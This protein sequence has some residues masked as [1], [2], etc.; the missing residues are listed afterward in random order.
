MKLQGIS[1]KSIVS[2]PGMLL[3]QSFEVVPEERIFSSKV[4]DNNLDNW[5]EWTR[6]EVALFLSKYEI[7]N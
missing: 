2:E 3:T 6:D 4:Y 5:T 7:E 1:I